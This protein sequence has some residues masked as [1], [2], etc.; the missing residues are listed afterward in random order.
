M[1]IF[2]ENW[3]PTKCGSTVTSRKTK[4]GDRQGSWASLL[5]VGVSGA[6]LVFAPLA[7]GAVHPWAYCA[8]GLA[9]T[10]A[11]LILLAAGLFRVWTPSGTGRFLPYPPVWWLALGLVVLV[12]LQVAPWPQGAV[13]VLSPGVWEIRT[14][15]NGFGLEDPLPLSLNPYA[16]LLQGLELWPAAALFF[17]LVY[18]LK[19]RNQIQRLVELILVVALFEVIYG[20]LNYRSPL[21]WGWLNHYT[22]DRLCGTFINSNHLA[23]FLTMAIL[24]GYG[25]F[26]AQGKSEAAPSGK[27]RS[28]WRANYL[29]SQ[30]RRFLLLFLLVC[31]A[32]G[33]IYTRSRGGL[34]SLFCGFALMVLALRG[35]RGR[36]GQILVIVLFL[37]V[38]VAYSLFLGS[39]ILARFQAMSD[40]GRYYAMKGSLAIFRDFPWLGAGLGTFPEL[41]Y[42]YQPASLQGTYFPQAHS[43]W[44]QLLAESGVAGFLLVAAAAWWFFSRLVRQWRQRRDP[45]ARG[46]GLGGLAALAAAGFHA[47]I[48]SPLHIPAIALLVAAVAAITY[49]AIYSRPGPEPEF[50]YP[51]LAFPGRRCVAT[52]ILLGLMGLQLAFGIQVYRHWRAERAAPMEIN[53]TRPL[54]RLTV[55]DFRRALALNR[56]NSKYYFGLAQVLERQS[57]GGEPARAEAEQ[58]FQTAIRLS[59]ANWLYHLHLAEYYLRHHRFDPSCYL[60]QAL[61]EFGAAAQLFPESSDRRARLAAVLIWMERS[62]PGLVPARLQELYGSVPAPQ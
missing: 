30:F 41:F 7:Y 8:L 34:V 60:P 4:P 59:P 46:L 56:W 13:Q 54:P 3:H 22:G 25:L 52:L 43:D 36:P 31:L 44:L 19:T 57:T 27:R 55:A 49:L 10:A 48:E 35:P 39:H 33:V 18:T 61:Q 16:T 37:T 42:R 47:L 21:I 45:F 29:E 20:F 53:S 1:A 51:T 2:G 40:A 6:L 28:R 5:G 15:G 32:V 9:V 62:H 17:L 26:L 14:L 23:T 50:F 12:L 58:A 24:L 11:S 38:A